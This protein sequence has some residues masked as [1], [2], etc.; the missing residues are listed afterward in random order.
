[1]RIWREYTFE[2]AHFLPH[3]SEDHKCRQLHGHS[4]RVQI[5]VSGAI[6]SPFGWVMDFADV[7]AAAKPVIAELDHSCLNDQIGNPTSERL[8]QWLWARLDLPGLSRIVV[9][10]TERSGCEYEGEE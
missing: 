5:H 9:S 2:A 3:V 7:D 8:A 4:Y 10:E 6:V 1:M